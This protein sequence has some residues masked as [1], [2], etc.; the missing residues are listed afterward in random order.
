[1][2]LAD[3][4]RG[5]PGASVE[6][7]GDYDVTGVRYDSRRVGPGDLFVAVR[8]YHVDG[9][10]YATDAARKGA[11]LALEPGS[12][13][14]PGAAVLRVADSRSAL[15]ELAAELLGRPAHGLLVAGVT[16][17]DGK[18]TTTYMAQHILEQSGVA[19]GLTSTVGFRLRGEEHYN[20]SG[21]TTTE[22]S[23][24]Q[25]WLARMRDAGLR[26]AVVE[27]T[28]HALVQGRV[29]ACE[30]D[31]AAFT[32]IGF[33]HMDFH[34][35]WED[36]LQ[37]K[38][39][40]VDMCA[41]SPAKGVPKTVVLNRD[42]ISWERLK[43]RP[44]ERR[45]TYSLDNDADFRAV[46]IWGDANGSR[47]RLV[48]PAG[49]AAVGLRLPARFNVYNALCAAGIAVAMGVEAEAIGDALSTFRGVR[50]RLEQV[51]L[52]QPFRVFID[53]AHSAGSLRSALAELRQVTDGRLIAVFG[54]T[55]RSDHDR[56]GMGHAA[57]EGAD[58]F[59]ITTDDPLDQDPAEIAA[60]VQSGVVG[61]QPGRDYVTV[62]DRR[63]AIR[64]AIEMARPGD[65][66]LLAGKGHE[67]TML[68]AAGREPW[69]ERAEAE[70][71]IRNLNGA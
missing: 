40:L 64:R 68:T 1:M 51:E 25:E 42:D 9:H 50:G 69:D 65:T 62:L 32:N 2:R 33:D 10:L 35:T 48:T 30:F 12:P 49:E 61:R 23:E 45:F 11:A 16:G 29:N 52:G 22:A 41:A 18:T 67:R 7:G 71:A 38:A 36:Y 55:A 14:P 39:R 54:S 20:E 31:V 34:G 59:V 46:D 8:G 28:S 37:A 4:A 43:D 57:G 63:T 21:Q 58:Y 44:I 24:L 13:A 70:A 60:D 27:A 47:F 17:T 53:F 66:V 15:A 26:A 3:L 19:S 5:V 56:P 6:A